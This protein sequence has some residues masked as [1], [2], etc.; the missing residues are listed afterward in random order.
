MN[1]N[2]EYKDIFYKLKELSDKGE[3][4]EGLKIDK[5]FSKRVKDE[6][7][8]IKFAGVK[9]P[10]Q[11]NISIMI[12]KKLFFDSHIVQVSGHSENKNF[13]IFFILKLNGNSGAKLDLLDF[14]MREDYPLLYDQ[15]HQFLDHTQNSEDKRKKIYMDTKLLLK[16][17]RGIVK[18]L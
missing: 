13:R 4:V 12:W 15:K 6:F 7:L 1:G 11:Y 17:F 18:S 10:Q 9:F 14:K 5:N 2:E 16:K 8:I 3:I